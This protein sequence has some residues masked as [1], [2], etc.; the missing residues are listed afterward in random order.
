MVGNNDF[1][2][3]IAQIVSMRMCRIATELEGN[4]SGWVIKPHNS[5]RHS[6]IPTN[7]CYGELCD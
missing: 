2:Q 3:K 6:R 1:V 7:T 4:G 5:K